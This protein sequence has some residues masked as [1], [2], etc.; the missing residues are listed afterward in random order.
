ME[1]MVDSFPLGL[2]LMRDLA[3]KGMILDFL[4]MNKDKLSS[5][6]VKRSGV[7]FPYTGGLTSIRLANRQ[8]PDN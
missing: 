8:L 7:G 5:D 4:P 6:E 1:E 3:L 2:G